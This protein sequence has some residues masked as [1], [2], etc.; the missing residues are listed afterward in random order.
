MAAWVRDHGGAVRGYLWGIVRRSDTADDLTQEVFYRAWRNRD[1]YRE[2]GQARAF[3]LRIADR[4]AC[5]QLRREKANRTKQETIKEVASSIAPHGDP[6]RRATDAEAAEQL[7]AALDQLSES[8]RRV[9]LLRY[10]GALSFHEIAATLGIPLSTAL[11]HCHRG[12]QALRS[13][14]VERET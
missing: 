8:Q 6:V 10:Y 12:L 13:Q 11:S 4:L 14:L 9:L 3:L 5:D 2:R 1:G 7:T